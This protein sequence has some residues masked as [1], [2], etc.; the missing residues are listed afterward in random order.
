MYY[1]YSKPRRIRVLTLAYQKDRACAKAFFEWERDYHYDR[2][3]EKFLA[4]WD[5]ARI[6]DAYVYAI[7][8]PPSTTHH[9]LWK[10]ATKVETDDRGRKRS[11][12][13]RRTTSTALQLAV[14]HAFTGSYTSRFR[15]SDRPSTYSCTCGEVLRDPDHILRE[16]RLF[17]QPRI[18]TAIRPT[19]L[20][21]SGSY[22]TFTPTVSS[23]S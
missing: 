16:C 6:R 9:R 20:S 1:A 12:H 15:P 3:M 2:M 23:Y 22:L 7:T 17:Y 18:D 13:H 19:T 8:P 14:D 4:Q 11:V 10:E 21:H 5:G